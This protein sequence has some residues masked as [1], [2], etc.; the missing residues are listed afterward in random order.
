MGSP[1]QKVIDLEAELTEMREI[2]EK[3]E[4]VE[5]ELYNQLGEKDQEAE[6]LAQK[7]KAK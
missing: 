3:R 2:N 7:L 1:T 6:Q 4:S 5:Q